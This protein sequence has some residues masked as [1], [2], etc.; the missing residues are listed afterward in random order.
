[1]PAHQDVYFSDESFRQM[2]R[3]RSLAEETGRSMVQLALAWIFGWPGVTSVLVGA[4]STAHIDQAFEAEAEGL[5]D[6]LLEMLQN[7]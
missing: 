5:Q 6:G 4:R 3:L 7:L 2:E 1:M